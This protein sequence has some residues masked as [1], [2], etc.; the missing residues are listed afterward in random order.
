MSMKRKYL[1]PRALALLSLLMFI[2][3][4]IL[5]SYLNITF[6]QIIVFGILYLLICCFSALYK[7]K[8]GYS[9]SVFLKKAYNILD[10]CLKYRPFDMRTK[11][12]ENVWRNQIEEGRACDFDV[13]PDLKYLPDK[14]YLKGVSYVLAVRKFNAHSFSFKDTFVLLAGLFF[15]VSPLLIWEFPEERQGGDHEQ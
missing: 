5:F 12:I 9:E 6:N 11:R 2:P 8:K 3:T 13:L 14:W 15:I 10:R 1:I 7:K 4:V